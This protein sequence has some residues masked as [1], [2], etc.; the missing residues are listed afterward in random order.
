MVLAVATSTALL[1][2]CS[3]SS[4]PSAPSS[5]RADCAGYG[6]WQSSAYVLPYP[7]GRSYE[8][9]TGNCDPAHSGVNRYGFD[10]RMP[11]GTEI[12]A[13]LGGTVVFVE[14]RWPDSSR[15]GAQ[16]NG[17][18]IEQDDGLFGNYWHLTRDGVLVA[19]GDRVEQG[20]LVAL[21][22]ASGT[23]PRHL[24]FH[25]SAC[26]P[27]CGSEPIN[28]RNTDPNPNGPTSGRHW[29]ALPY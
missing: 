5:S 11:I 4:S 12:T 23:G 25:V 3:S 15:S 17:L 24:H 18:V 22:G 1:V 28:F 6:A 20:D 26:Y 21:S 13:A 14:E 7:V 27:G 19:V 29:P 8:V 10:F 9:M 2:G 16:N